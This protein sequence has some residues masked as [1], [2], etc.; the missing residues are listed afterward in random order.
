MSAIR[1]QY[2]TESENKTVL[3]VLI[4]IMV[5]ALCATVLVFS[6][7]ANMEADYMGFGLIGAFLPVLAV[8][9]AFLMGIGAANSFRE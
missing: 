7:P 6:W 3:A 5:V 4:T 8:L 1:N 9:G 2:K